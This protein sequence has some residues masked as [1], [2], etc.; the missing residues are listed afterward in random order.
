MQKRSSARL[1]TAFAAAFAV[2]VVVA[3]LVCRGP[4][5][6]GH[7]LDS[8]SRTS[9]FGGLAALVAAVLAFLA[10]ARSV[11]A[12]DANTRATLRE[13]ARQKREDRWWDTARWAYDAFARADASARPL[14]PEIIA[15]LDADQGRRP[16]TEGGRFIRVFA[17]TVEKQARTDL[18]QQT[19]QVADLLS[20]APEGPAGGRPWSD[21]P[22]G[23][24][25]VVSSDGHLLGWAHWV[26][27]ADGRPGR[28]AAVPVDLLSTRDVRLVPVSVSRAAAQA[29][30]LTALATR[31][32]V[33][34]APVLTFDP[35]QS[36][37]SDQLAGL[38]AYYQNPTV[39]AGDSSWGRDD[40]ETSASAAEGE[41]DDH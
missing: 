40:D 29:T 28:W 32:Q 3:V 36:P 38:R 23:G 19:Q 21:G 33:K 1:G 7:W 16:D 13:E 17:E 6:F 9:G 25:P 22:S 14:I 5:A 20:S 2:G 4:S 39:T 18:K 26:A 24:E 37:T 15:H 31:A 30:H 27:E 41:E 11:Q 12:A 10:A 8:F 34:D 35:E